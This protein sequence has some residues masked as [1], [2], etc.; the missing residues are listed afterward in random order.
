MKDIKVSWLIEWRIE[1]RSEGWKLMPYA[2]SSRKDARRKMAEL[3]SR[4][5]APAMR[6]RKYVLET[7]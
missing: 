4:Q 1:R 7:K 3:Q 6:A 2:F 5:D